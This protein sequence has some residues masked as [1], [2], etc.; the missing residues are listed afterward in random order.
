[1]GV[2]YANLFH[3]SDAKD[4]FFKAYEMGEREESL[5]CY[6]AAWKMT[7]EDKEYEEA[8]RINPVF[9]KHNLEL[10]SFLL[11]LKNQWQDSE[12]PGTLKNPVYDTRMVN[13]TERIKKMEQ[14]VS[15]WKEEYRMHIEE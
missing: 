4:Y 5:L 3:F 15:E 6:L 7:G 14:I 8:L 1:M 11:E 2:I 12:I 10:D 9:Q 13:R